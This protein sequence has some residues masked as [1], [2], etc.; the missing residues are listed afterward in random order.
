ML[1]AN[2]WNRDS[3][4]RH[5]LPMAAQK[6]PAFV[7]PSLWCF[8]SSHLYFSF[9]SARL[10]SRAVQQSPI[11]LYTRINAEMND[12]SFLSSAWIA[13]LIMK[14]VLTPSLRRDRIRQWRRWNAWSRCLNDII[15]LGRGLF[16]N[17]CDRCVHRLGIDVWRWSLSLL[18]SFLG[19]ERL[20]KTWCTYLAR[21]KRLVIELVFHPVHQQFD[22]LRSWYLE[23]SLHILPISPKILEF[24]SST[25]DRARL[26]GTKF[27]ERAI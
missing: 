5:R 22:I 25:H 11:S 7:L 14:G 23:R 4:Q 15:D 6:F 19:K 27:S 10:F 16:G 26:L 20:C 17:D 13:E 9:W 1:A 12:I 8:W 21:E 3:Q 18:G 24:L 2:D